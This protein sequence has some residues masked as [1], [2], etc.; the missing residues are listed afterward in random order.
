VYNYP[1][2]HAQLHQSV[3][4]IG[5]SEVWNLTD[6]Q[7]RPL[8]GTN[9]TIA[10]IDTGID[11]THDD[12]GN[13][14]QSQFLNGT[15]AK[16]IGGYDFFSNDLNPMDDHGHGTHVAATA[17]GN[18]TLN[19]VAPN[20]SLVAYKVLSQWGWGFSSDIISAIEHAMDPNQDGNTSDHYDIA[21]LS[22]GGSGD[23]NDLKSRAV[24]RAVEAGV[25][26]VVAGGNSGPSSQTLLSPGVAREAITVGATDKSDNIASFSSRGPTSI[27]TIKP[28]IMAPGVS[29][30]AAQYGSYASGS[31]CIDAEHIAISGTSMATP[32]IA[33]AAALLLQKFPDYTPLEIKALLK[34]TAIDLG[35][36]YTDQGWGRV[37]VVAKNLF[38]FFI[39]CS[40]EV[41]CASRMLVSTQERVGNSWG[42]AHQRVVGC[43]FGAGR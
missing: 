38:R 32:H 28:D 15:C 31:E 7:G 24:D 42:I 25:I 23:P 36:N 39:I 29:I 2:H 33:G 6:S 17:A 26:V 5:A 22:L 21:S 3:P 16:V 18:G 27:N 35:F 37:N 11:Y 10:I 1:N 4:L 30:C 9:I 20:A 41:S 12:L 13:C 19:G 8:L 40:V 14:T 43:R 34:G